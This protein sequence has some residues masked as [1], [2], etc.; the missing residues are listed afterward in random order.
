MQLQ[1]LANTLNMQG[2]PRLHEHLSTAAM[3]KR[4]IKVAEAEQKADAISQ[5]EFFSGFLV[6][7]SCQILSQNWHGLYVKM[8]LFIWI[9]NQL[10]YICD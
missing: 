1:G 10:Y 9:S 5:N 6:R 7:F 4:R 2:V 8:L 3:M